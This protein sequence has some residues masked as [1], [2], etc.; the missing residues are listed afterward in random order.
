MD[1]GA[2]A[3]PK[4]KGKVKGKGE[5][6]GKGKGKGKVYPVP[7]QRVP[8]DPLGKKESDEVGLWKEGHLYGAEPYA[9]PQTY[10]NTTP[11]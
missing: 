1:D 3:I 11:P 6:R 2:L 9:Q 7:Q 4:G 8:A 5:G 10:R